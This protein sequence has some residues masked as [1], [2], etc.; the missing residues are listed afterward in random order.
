M[1]RMGFGP[2]NTV[3]DHER[4]PSLIDEGIDGEI[5]Q[6]RDGYP[7]RCYV[8]KG[9]TQV[10]DGYGYQ[11]PLLNHLCQPKARSYQKQRSVGGDINENPSLESKTLERL[12]PSRLKSRNQT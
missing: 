2:I 3:G 10:T 7:K 6:R 11:N 1:S 8:L 4:S 9:I 12:S 5:A